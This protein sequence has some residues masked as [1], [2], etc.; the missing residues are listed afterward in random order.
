MKTNLSEEKKTVELE[1]ENREQDAPTE[2][3]LAAEEQ[4]AEEETPEISERDS[5][6]EAIAA[7]RVE[8]RDEVEESADNDE[9][10]VAAAEEDA[11]EGDEEDRQDSEETL[12]ADGAEEDSDDDQMVEIIVD[13]QKQM[14]P[15]SQLVE[16]GTKTMQKESAADLKLQNAALREKQLNQREEQLN[17]MLQKYSAVTDDFDADKWQADFRDA[18]VDDE[19]KAA[20]MMG[21]MLKK[22]R[23]QNQQIASMATNFAQTTS[24][25]INEQKTSEKTKM[26]NLFKSEFPDLAKD[27]MLIQKANE[28]TALIKGKHPNMSKEDVVIAAGKAVRG[29]YHNLLGVTTVQGQDEQEQTPTDRK[30]SMPAPIKKSS[31]RKPGKKK[32][33]PLTKKQVIAGIKE[34]RNQGGP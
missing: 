33:A 23:T 7:K 4:A 11:A 12:E 30:R 16:A 19:D 27:K 32:A 18:L 31:A 28:A 2:E 1:D 15:V 6:I 29:Y 21:T 3:A 9:E 25:Y 24:N 34:S 14:V 5:R 26:L 10:G 17:A 13:G 8:D 20:E 22:M